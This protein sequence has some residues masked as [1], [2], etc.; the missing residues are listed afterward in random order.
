MMISLITIYLPA[1][2]REK[3]LEAL[4]MY[5]QNAELCRGCIGCNV[6]QSVEIPNKIIYWE[7]W[8]SRQDMEKHIHSPTYRKLLE[9]IEQSIKKP[10]IKYFTISK[11]EGLEV[12]KEVRSSI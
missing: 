2:R 4:K 7:E 12:V 1:K 9:I 8:Q 6:W 5:K 3:V 10:K 11:V